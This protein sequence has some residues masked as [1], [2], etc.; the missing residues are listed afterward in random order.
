MCPTCPMGVSKMGWGRY[1]PPPAPSPGKIFPHPR[2]RAKE[3]TKSES[4]L[5]ATRLSITYN[6]RM[7][8]KR[9]LIS[10]QLRDAIL[11]ADV[12]CYRIAKETELSEA[13]LSRFMN[14]VSGLSLDSIDRIGNYL[15]LDIATPKR[16][17]K[18]KKG[19]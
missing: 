7:A 16:K 14:G 10:E 12:S 15:G 19:K 13:L 8:A 18:P 11:N 17:A 1:F 5:L 9:K 2:G 4:F 3:K 6:G